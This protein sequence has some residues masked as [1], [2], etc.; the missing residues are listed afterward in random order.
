MKKKKINQ[1]VNASFLLTQYHI[2][3][4]KDIRPGCWFGKDKRYEA[5][6]RKHS[7]TE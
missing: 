4:G 1:K 7:E 3:N 6:D 5:N 2:E